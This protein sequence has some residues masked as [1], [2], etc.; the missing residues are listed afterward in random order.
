[1]AKKMMVLLI[2][3]IF[4]LVVFNNYAWCQYYKSGSELV[5]LWRAYQLVESH[6]ATQSEIIDG[7]MFMGYMEGV[8]DALRDKF[9]RPPHVTTSQ[10]CNIAGKYL[11][12]HPNEWHENGAD[13][14]MRSL[15]DAFPKKR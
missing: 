3:V 6:K 4:T 13:L 11:D 15:Q 14:V 7:V 10:L 12:A 5:R 2:A 8:A 9:N 1:M